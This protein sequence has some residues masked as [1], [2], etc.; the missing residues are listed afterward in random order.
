MMRTCTN[1]GY[2]AVGMNFRGCGGVP[3]QTPRGYN[4]A[5]TGDVRHVVNHI[6]ARLGAPTAD[7]G[8][9]GADEPV[10]FLVGHSL[11]ANIVIKYAGEEGLS[12]TLPESVAGVVTLGNPMALNTFKI[13]KFFSPIMNIGAK[14]TMLKNWS[15]L[16]RVTSP[17]IHRAIRQALKSFYLHQFDE[18]LVPTF[19]RNDTTYPFGFH[20]GF[21]DGM[22]YW[23]EGS[24]YRLSRYVSVPT[25]QVISSDDFLVAA[26]FKEKLAFSISNPNVMVLETTC[27][28]HLGWHESPPGDSNTP[29]G[30]GSSWADVVTV[31][32]IEANLATRRERSK[33]K[34]P[35]T[36]GEQHWTDGSSLYPRSR[37]LAEAACIRSKL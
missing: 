27:G 4:G 33:G 36:Q 32:F 29:F 6:V 28:G 3:L 9:A 20:I 5:Y 19:A 7:P 10:L 14:L 21:T 13:S 30:V 31:D 35:S 15:A 12:N 34:A 37:A 8:D 16:A 2:I 22:H 23:T 24:S 1:R 17:D 18:A 25:L 26:P 11:G